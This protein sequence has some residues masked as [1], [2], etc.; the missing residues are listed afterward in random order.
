[1]VVTRLTSS[2][3]VACINPMLE[4]KLEEATASS[5]FSMRNDNVNASKSVLSTHSSHFAAV[6]E[7]LLCTVV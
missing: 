7:C 2:Y 5:Y 4:H 6:T 1:M 3:G